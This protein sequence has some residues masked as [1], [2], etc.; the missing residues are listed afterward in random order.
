MRHSERQ[1]MPEADVQRSAERHRITTKTGPEA[2]WQALEGEAR[3]LPSL[4]ERLRDSPVA[5]AHFEQH[6]GDAEED[7]ELRNQRILRQRQAANILR[8]LLSPFL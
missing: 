7:E 3:K 4:T 6:D 5:V 2:D 8:A 1:L